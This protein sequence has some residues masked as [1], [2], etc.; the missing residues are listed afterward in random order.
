MRLGVIQSNYIPWRGY[1]DFIRSCDVFVL[2]DCVQYTKQDWRNRN[3]VKLND[4]LHWISVPVKYDHV[5]TPIN[6]IPIIGRDW[7]PY[8][9]GVFEN[10]FRRCPHAK[11]AISLWESV[12]EPM[13]SPLNQR[14]IQAICDYL[15]IKTPLL[16]SRQFGLEGVKTERLI[17]L[18]RKV[19]ADTYLSGPAAKG[20]LDVASM[21][22]AGIRVE[23]KEYHYDPYPQPWG[24]FEGAV[25]VLDLIANTGRDARNHIISKVKP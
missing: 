24:A 25:T 23:W 2:Y 3:K 19:G 20:Y 9:K 11:E 17:T 10:A 8:H 1:F 14:L 12:D 15:E 5:H 13:L 6:E 16:D 18:C 4:G 22:D 21:N 7:R